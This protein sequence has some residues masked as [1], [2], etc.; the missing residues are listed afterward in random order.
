MTRIRVDVDDE[1]LAEASR[2]F[3]T[4]TARDTINGALRE[5]AQRLRRAEGLAELA[6]PGRASAFEDLVDRRNDRRSL[7]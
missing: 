6:T 5:V 3:G 1:A 4:K 2:L 7:A